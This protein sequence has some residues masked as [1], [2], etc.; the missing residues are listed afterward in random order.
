M[1]PPEGGVESYPPLT[2][3]ILTAY[4]FDLGFM[5]HGCG[6]GMQRSEALALE[7]PDLLD[8]HRRNIAALESVADAMKPPPRP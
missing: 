8:Q 2:E 1:I 5:V 3:E 7:W 6:L 4:V